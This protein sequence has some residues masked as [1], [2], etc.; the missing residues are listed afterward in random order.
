MDPKTT[1]VLL[2][3]DDPNLRGVLSDILKMKGIE[4]IPAKTGT[5]ALALS[6]KQEFDVALIDLKLEDM[7]GLEVLRGIK[8]H[9]PATECIML[10]GHAT[11][12]TAIEAINLGAYSY[13]QKPY[14]V[15]QL[16][17]A[18]QRAAE[19]H[20]SRHAL[21]DN[22]ARFRSLIEN[23]TDLICILNPDATLRYI[24]P[25][26]TSLL[27]YSID[28]VVGGSNLQKYIHPNDLPAFIEGFQRCLQAFDSSPVSLEL[29]ILHKNGS[30]LTL[31]GTGSNQLGQPAIEGV[32]VN[33][34]D[35]TQR[36]RVETERQALFEIMQGLASTNNLNELL[37]LIH[38]S[39]AKVIDAG[40]YFVVLYDKS[41]GLFEE[42]YAV[43]QYDAIMSPSK[44][45]KSITSYVF[46]TGESLLLS[47]VKFEELVSRGEVELV[48]TNSPSW[49][50]VPLKTPSGTVGV[51][52]VQNYEEV[53]CYSERDR[54]FL[55]SVAVQVSLAIERKR[56]E[57]VLRT[58]ESSLQAVLQSTA[59]GILAVG[60][61]N[62]VLYTNERF[63]EMWRIPQAVLDSKDDN[64]LLQ[65]VLDQLVDPQ[66]FV[67]KVHELYMSEEKGFDTLLFKDGRVFERLTN[68]LLFG[69]ELRG[70]V[71]SF[72]DVTTRQQ[73][74]ETLKES[75][76]SYQKLVEQIP[77]VI[78]R[79]ALDANASTLFIGPQI[80]DLTGYSAEEWVT[81]PD[82]WVKILHTEDRSRALEEQKHHLDTGEPFIS[83]YR[84]VARDGHIVWV[85]DEAVSILDSSGA[86]LYDQGVFIDI[87]ERK[88]AEEKIRLSE[89]RYRMLAE[90]MSDTI[91]LMDMDLQ[92]TYISPSVTRLRGY[93]IDEINSIPRD[94]QLPPD[95]LQRALQ[96]LNDTL[97][98]SNL[99]QPSDQLISR[100]IDLEFSKKDGT[101]YWSENTFSLI[102]DSQGQ[103]I[104]ILGV[105]RDI[106]DRKRAEDA[107]QQSELRLRT[108]VE[109]TQ[110]LLVNVDAEGHF[111]YAN[112]ATARAVGFTSPQELIGKSYLHFV[113]PQDRQQVLATFMDQAIKL[114]PYGVQD[115][116]IVDTQ[117]IVKWF[118]FQSN[119]LIKEGKAV[120][121]TGV[122]QDI[123]ERKQMEET[124]EQERILLRTLVDNLPDRI[125]VMDAQGRKILSNSADWHASGGRSMEDVIGKTD[126]DI[127]PPDLAANYWALDQTVID[128]G[129]SII[130]REEPGLDSQ[131][132]PVWVLSSKV[133]LRDGQGNIIGLVGIG[134]DITERKQVDEQIRRRL[135]ELEVLHEVSLSINILLEP[136]NIA[137]KMVEILSQKLAWNHASIRLFHAGTRKI[138]FLAI[139]K[140]GLTPNQAEV[141][142][143]RLNMIFSSTSIGLSGWVIK[144]GRTIR[145][146]DVKSDK[147]YHAAFPEICSGIYVPL[148]IGKRAIGSIAVESRQ[149]NRFSLED[150][151]LLQTLAAQSAI[152]FENAR[153]YQ[154]AVTA[155]KRKAAL[156]QGSLE[157]VRAGQNIEALCKAVHHAV[158]QVMSAEAFT[159]SLLTEDGRHVE[160]PYLYDLG[161]RHPNTKLSV[162]AGVT[163]RVISSRKPLR[164]KDVQK[165][166]GPR[167]IMVGDSEPTRSILSVPLLAMEKI[168]GV[169]S[170]QS[171]EADVYTLEDQIFLETLASEAAVSFE[172]ARLFEQT[173]RRL[174]ELESLSQ[175]SL[176]LTSA[177]DLQPLLENILVGACKA[178]PA[179]E[180][181]TILLTEPD[182]RLRLHAV[183]GYSDPRL[184]GLILPNQNG[185]AARVALER[186]SIKIDDV[187]AEY[188]VPYTGMFGE[189]DAVKSGIAAPLIVK[190]K[191]IGVISLDNAS[192]K[193]AFIESDLNLLVTFASSAAV[194]I[195]NARLFTETQQRLHRISSLHS[196]D[197]AIGA[198]VDTNVTLSI[199]LDHIMSEL[200]ADAAA[201]LLLNPLTR[202]L[203]YS[204]GRG[205]R[206][207]IME[208]SR[209]RLGEGLAG[210]SALQR[211]PIHITDLREPDAVDQVLEHPGSET[212]QATLRYLEGENFVS[213][214][215]MP[216]IAKGQVQGVLE[217]F[218]RTP[219][220]VDQEWI[221]FF[222]M[223]AGQTAIA[224][225]N[226]HL[227]ENLQQSN[228]ELTLAYDATI[229][230]WS[231]ALELRDEE[232]EGHTRRVTE[233]TL[234]LIHAMGIADVETEHIR[235]GSLLHDIGKIAVPD[236]ILL[237][238]GPLNEVEWSVMR[239][240]PQY[241]YNMLAPITYLA[242]A[243]HIPWCHHEKWDGSGYPRGIK[244]DAIPMAA[245]IFAIA[246]VFDA[247]TSNRPYRLAWTREKAMEYIQEQSGKQ[248]DPRVVVAFMDLM[249]DGK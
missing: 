158:R 99:E 111:T 22:E 116:R 69:T 37:H 191:L 199:V 124:M 161:I 183:S 134:R 11:Q 24:S 156:H 236:S 82:L 94:Q 225:D 188:E 166:R 45:E 174:T 21:Q 73:A 112:E 231:Q 13:F 87:T 6:E 226:G 246:D 212:A 97:S 220:P 176:S 221:T 230:G 208:G 217:I 150:E 55:V 227:F 1:S 237:K 235:R 75:Q 40:N 83:D 39:I 5:D 197:A 201:V 222:E 129:T 151:R 193:A 195:E 114:E 155:A 38:H 42:V 89:E 216:L 187:Q 95:S 54:D 66:K 20:A 14:E 233:L 8:T 104:A 248:F 76:Q 60:N 143:D 169:L 167:P 200:K 131:G 137:R 51:M 121:Q 68:P 125:Y 178:I 93:T 10:T 47:Q 63:A 247:L 234:R 153:L 110:A 145:S 205:F 17:V 72:R 115:F 41:K 65:C 148:M 46:R 232:T 239:Q 139:N 30:W 206:V 146:A 32:I 64:I 154:E 113:H 9:S 171:R 91:W 92:T 204:T 173:R 56:A 61:Q 25:S 185:Y 23:S 228:L 53:N 118:H 31:E 36:K 138:E 190:G 219:L 43:D 214:H 122:A 86:P 107:F 141:E 238:S 182:G 241:A 229:Q 100:T 78:Y 70:R 106:S 209:L 180:K 77:G 27:G 123:T 184:M 28:E 128:T 218:R 168:I 49:L 240:H 71:W 140:P 117:G 132:N 105:G 198:S 144:H 102:N 192:Q 157:I 223:V 210:R 224:I 81:D 19:K 179:A 62:E 172:N 211:R 147:R 159:V 177:I 119:L 120:G 34:R 12:T 84:L 67:K 3:D 74:E 2:L 136:R 244:G 142:I 57:D 18:I 133:P 48:G 164:L 126:F 58:T 207:Q 7:S 101:T 35:V 213:Y 165:S 186:T 243:I 242:P 127:Y 85:H 215:A 79:D 152:A 160:A 26:I 29:R 108:I 96:L 44:L 33:A 135:A 130:N 88:L 203:E 170:V 162:D 80:K 181:G 249:A 103:P 245:R 202:M 4:S 90:N 98:S 149:S 50:G 163:G 109:G 15:D 189:I 194:A 175:V 196:I 59:D 16:L 52:V